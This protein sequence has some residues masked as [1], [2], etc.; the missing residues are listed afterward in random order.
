MLESFNAVLERA[1]IYNRPRC[2][3]PQRPP[4]FRRCARRISRRCR[5]SDPELHDLFRFMA[6]A[7]LRFETLRMRIVDRRTTT[8]GDETETHDSGCATRAWP[9]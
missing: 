4:S 3:T 5:T 8:H 6:E 7:E 9:R 1:R 2:T